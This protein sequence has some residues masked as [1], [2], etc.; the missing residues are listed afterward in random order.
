VSEKLVY[1][2]IGI[3]RQGFSGKE[4]VLDMHFYEKPERKGKFG[5]TP[6]K[7]SM[8]HASEKDRFGDYQM[9]PGAVIRCIFPAKRLVWRGVDYDQI[10][11]DLYRPGM[12]C[13]VCT[14]NRGKTALIERIEWRIE[15]DTVFK[16]ATARGKAKG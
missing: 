15:A 6:D 1:V 13:D 5:Y 7:K 14:N 9:L 10:W 3:L 16:S 8:M 4:N 11:F 12:V 2:R